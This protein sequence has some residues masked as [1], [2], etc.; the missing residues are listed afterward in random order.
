MPNAHPARLDPT[1]IEAWSAEINNA[2]AVTQQSP[3]DRANAIFELRSRYQRDVL[4]YKPHVR[5]S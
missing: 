4:G 2:V 5:E 1:S 3:Y